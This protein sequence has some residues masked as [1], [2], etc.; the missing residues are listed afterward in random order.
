[1]TAT[2]SNGQESWK[3]TSHCNE[4]VYGGC[5]DLVSTMRLS[6]LLKQLLLQQCQKVLQDGIPMCRT[7][8]F[9]NFC[10][11]FSLCQLI[12]Y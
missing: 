12:G 5:S 8:V 1:M 7:G 9:Y 10:L 3:T 4:S 6:A 11:T 2:Y